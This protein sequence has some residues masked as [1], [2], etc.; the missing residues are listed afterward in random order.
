[1][2]Y[3]DKDSLHRSGFKK[4]GTSNHF[5]FANFDE[6][7]VNVTNE[8]WSLLGSILKQ[9]IIGGIL[10][11]DLN[12]NTGQFG[13]I[14]QSFTTEYDIFFNHYSEIQNIKIRVSPKVSAASPFF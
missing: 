5:F 8:K 1:M 4:V 10:N 3:P 2:I 9:N 12:L 11:D 7:Y 6:I 13:L 14:F